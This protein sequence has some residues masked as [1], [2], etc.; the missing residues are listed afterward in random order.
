MTSGISTVQGIW[1]PYCLGCLIVNC[2]KQ[3][4]WHRMVTLNRSTKSLVS[5]GYLIKRTATAHVALTS[6]LEKPENFRGLE[7]VTN[8][9]PFTGDATWPVAVNLA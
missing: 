5:Q 4:R 9:A 1:S 8:E 6:Y 2:I 7:L 3:A